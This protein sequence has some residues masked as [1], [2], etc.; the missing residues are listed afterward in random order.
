MPEYNNS[1]S[2]SKIKLILCVVQY[3]IEPVS[4]RRFRSKV[5]VDYFLQTGNKPNKK[6][7][8]DA[9]ANVS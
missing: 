6:A 7:K 3:Y 4:G 2:M 5:E 8:P 9:D 1:S